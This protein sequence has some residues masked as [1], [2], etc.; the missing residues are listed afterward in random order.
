MGWALALFPSPT[1]G[2]RGH[3]VAGLGLD[4]ALVEVHARLPLQLAPA[5]VHRGMH[6]NLNTC[7]NRYTPICGCIYTC[8]EQTHSSSVNELESLVHTTS[9]TSCTCEEGSVGW[10]AGSVGWRAG[11]VGWRAGSVG[12]SA[13]SVG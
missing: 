3:A 8:K 7:K 11:S 9:T 2:S 4:V 13:G 10:R 5:A 6:T 1:G 12:W